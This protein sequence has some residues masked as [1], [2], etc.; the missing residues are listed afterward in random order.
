MVTAEPM[1][2]GWERSDELIDVLCDPDRRLPAVVASAHPSFSFEEWK[3]V[4]GHVMWH[5]PGLA[6]IYILDPL[7]TR[8]FAESIGRTHAV[9]GGAVRTYMPDVDPAVVADSLRHRVLSAARIEADPGRATRITSMLPR[10]LAAELP[11][12]TA[13]AGVNRTLLTRAHGTPDTGDREGLRSQVTL[14]ASERDIALNLA[15]EQE[16]R[17]NALFAQ[18]ESALAELTELEQRLLHLDGQV[19]SPRRH[20]VIAGRPDVAFLPSEDPSAPPATFAELLE[21]LESDLSRVEFTGDMEEPLSLDQSPESSTWVRSSWEILRAMQAYA[22]A[23]SAGEF[24]GDFKMWC[25]SPPSGVYA[26][27]GGKVARDE[28]ATVRNNPKLR[29]KRE[30]RV[31]REIDPSC[32]LFMGGH[33]RIGASGAGQI[34]PRLYFHDAVSSNGKIY[35][36]YLGRHLTN[37]RS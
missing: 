23:K 35:I 28:S 11:L 7:G 27:P 4:I 5:L 24:S 34:S 32:R 17:A 16:Q 20:L 13:L 33:V 37:T 21:W 15:E 8:L 2:I 14:L 30:F 3:K 25:E 19:R 6:S 31:A 29:R 36:G 10:R 18:R 9:W 1:L 22:D 26:V 12:P